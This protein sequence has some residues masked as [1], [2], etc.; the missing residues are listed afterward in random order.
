[1]AANNVYLM[2]LV[3][4]LLGMLFLGY[5]MFRAKD[6]DISCWQLIASRGADSKQYADIDKVGKVL[7]LVFVLSRAI[8]LTYLGTLTFEELVLDVTYLSAISAFA[9]YLRAKAGLPA[10]QQAP[11]QAATVTTTT[12]TEVKP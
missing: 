12:L 5:I 9:A 8:Y 6:N 3:A 11:A 1:M 4:V 7:L 10:E 2:A